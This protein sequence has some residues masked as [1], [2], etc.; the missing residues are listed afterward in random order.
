[1]LYRAQILVGYYPYG[2]GIFGPR[3]EAPEARANFTMS[4]N[5]FASAM[6]SYNGKEWTDTKTHAENA[7]NYM[8]KAE[9]AERKFMEGS[10]NSKIVHFL[11]LITYPS[12]IIAILLIIYIVA[13]IFRKIKPASS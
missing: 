8:N 10:I 4:L 11:D 13:A 9:L 6:L 1:M 5:E 7:I 2:I 3:Y 12:I